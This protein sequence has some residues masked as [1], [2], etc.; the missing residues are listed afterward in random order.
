MPIYEYRCKNCR[1]RVSLFFQSLRESSTPVCPHCGSKELD[2]L[3]SSFAIGKGE[4][5]LRKDFYEDMLSDTRLVRGLEQN[6]PRAIAEWSRKMS[7]AIGEEISPEY[8]DIMNRLEAGEP[9]EKVMSEAE[10]RMGGEDS[11]TTD[12]D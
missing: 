11:T 10:E 1:R 3:F 5:Y 2:R 8:E 12:E 7:Q 4:S 6:D 9:V